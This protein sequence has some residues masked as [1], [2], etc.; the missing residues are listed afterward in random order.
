MPGSVLRPLRVSSHRMLATNLSA[1]DGVISISHTGNVSAAPGV[2][3]L[4]C[5]GGVCLKA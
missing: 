2:S 1:D 5:Q 3:Q 4:Q